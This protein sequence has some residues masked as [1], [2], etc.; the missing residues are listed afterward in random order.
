[1]MAAPAPRASRADRPARDAVTGEPLVAGTARLPVRD[2]RLDNPRGVRMYGDAPE[3]T[4]RPLRLHTAQVEEGGL[5]GH[6]FTRQFAQYLARVLPVGVARAEMER[7]YWWASAYGRRRVEARFIASAH[8]HI[9]SD[10]HQARSEGQRRYQL[11]LALASGMRDYTAL[12]TETGRSANWLQNQLRLAERFAREAAT[13]VNQ[14][15]VVR[16]LEARALESRA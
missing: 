12:M 5:G 9:A 16:P 8:A 14:P 4:P 6:A 3:T 10:P 15:R 2:E 7:R 1:M 13:A 11:A